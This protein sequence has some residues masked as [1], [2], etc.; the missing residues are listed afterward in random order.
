MQLVPI[1]EDAWVAILRDAWRRSE[2]KRILGWRT[3]TYGGGDSLPIHVWGLAGEYVVGRLLG[4]SYDTGVH[5][6]DGAS[7]FTLPGGASVEVKT[8]TKWGWDYVPA[9]HSKALGDWLAL[10]WPQHTNPLAFQKLSAVLSTT[11]YEVDNSGK[12]CVAGF[13]ESFEL[14]NAN[15]KA[16]CVV[17]FASRE[18]FDKHAVEI[19]QLKNQRGLGAEWF[20]DPALLQDMK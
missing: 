13:K 2:P 12:L 16:L 20:K 1:P 19:P 7:D 11:P 9:R 18:T 8:R 6:T 15:P 10:V 3:R 14:E 4:L 17:G 5:P